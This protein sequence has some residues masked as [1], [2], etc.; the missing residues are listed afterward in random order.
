MA[1]RC[2]Q[3]RA[4]PGPVVASPLSARAVLP[5]QVPIRANARA[6][7]SPG[8]GEV[9]P[10]D[11]IAQARVETSPSTRH[12]KNRHRLQHPWQYLL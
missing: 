7:T 5:G 6:W 2:D 12:R 3:A 1:G 8:A 9:T 11:V 10:A 4:W